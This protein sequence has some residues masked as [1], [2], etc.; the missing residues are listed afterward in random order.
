MNRKGI[1]LAVLIALV[2][3]VTTVVCIFFAPQLWIED[4]GPNEDTQATTTTEFEVP[5]ITMYPADADDDTFITAPSLVETQPYLPENP[6]SGEI[7]G[8]E[9][10]DDYTPPS[11]VNS[12]VY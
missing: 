2:A 5:N 4:D 6:Q 8:S 12:E 10:D 9:D 11:V 1:L 7:V 3:I